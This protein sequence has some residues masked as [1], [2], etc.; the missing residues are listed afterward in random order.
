ME[1]RTA[2]ALVM[3]DAFLSVGVKQFDVIETDINRVSHGFRAGRNA[4][5]MNLLLPFLIPRCWEFHQNLI[6][7]PR[8]PLCGALAQL[9]DLDVDQVARVRPV[10]FLVVETSPGNY[11]V[12]LSI[13][14]GTAEFVKRLMKGVHSDRR[15][16]CAGR[17]AG[18]P[19]CKPKY[20]PNFPV[21]TVSSVRPGAV[22][23]PVE[24]EDLGLVAAP[25]PLA[26]RCPP[27]S[28][29]GWPDYERCLRAAPKK[30][31]GTPDRSCADYMWAK[32]AVERGNSTSAVRAK[33][34][35]VSGK[36]REEWERGNQKYVDRTV[37]AAMRTL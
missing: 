11:Q 7:R 21:V 28:N 34:L 12:W 25:A 27:G 3:V 26:K 9:D 32:W 15:A 5:A 24:L 4:G 29:R 35:E 8:R 1:E 2:E 22:V 17:I 37:D 16:N 31:D 23:K 36:A 13:G 33:L 14:G 30:Q 18:S 20:A 10:A 19:N 6:V